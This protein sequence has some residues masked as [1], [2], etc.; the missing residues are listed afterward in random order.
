MKIQA[1]KPRPILNKWENNIHCEQV[2]YF[3][4]LEKA[5]L[6]L[7]LSEKLLPLKI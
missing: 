7:N 6:D 4:Q 2:L 1:E 5:V 3:L